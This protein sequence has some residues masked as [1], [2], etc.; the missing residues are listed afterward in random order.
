MEKNCHIYSISTISSIYVV[1]IQSMDETSMLFNVYV[2]TD[3]SKNEITTENILPVI[4]L[5]S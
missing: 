3:C 5:G 1:L 4:G 2:P